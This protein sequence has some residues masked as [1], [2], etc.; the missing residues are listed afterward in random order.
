MRWRYRPFQAAAIAAL[1]AL[2]T[3]CAV[4]APLY[5]RAM[6][7]ALADLAIA[8]ETPAE[9]G[10]QLRAEA[11]E[12]EFAG[13]PTATLPGPE[14]VLRKVPESM[15]AF[16]LDP[17]LSYSAT[18]RP[19]PEGVQDPAGSITWRDGECDHLTFV[20]G[21]CPTDVGDIAISTADARIFGYDVGTTVRV[22]GAESGATRLTV[23]GVYEQVP[24]DFWFGLVLTGYSGV[25]DPVTGVKEH[26]TW[27]SPRATF[28]SPDL[29]ELPGASSSVDLPLDSDNIGVDD[30]LV[31]SDDIAGFEAQVRHDART[32]VEIHVVTGLPDI[33]QDIRVQTDQSRVTVPLLMAQ[34]GLLAV[35]VLWLVLLAVTEQRRP[36]V[37]LAR[38][39]GRGRRGARALLLGELL[40]VAL[41]GV[42]PGVVAALLGSWFART[43]LLPGHA[44]FELRLP[45][46]A[47]VVLAAA[48][49]ALVTVV[50]VSR[51]VREPVE[52]LLRR[53]PPRH[54]RWGL[55]V[56]DALVI[57]GAGTLVVAFATGGLDGPI[58][59]AAPGLLAIVVGLV[60]AHLTSPTASIVGRRLLR[61]GRVRSGVSVLDAARSPATRRI[62]AVVT[63]ASALAVFSAD[64]YVVGDRNR[65]S[66]AAQEAGARLVASVSGNNLD[67]V[68]EAL[69][70]V[71][72]DGQRATPVVRVRPAGDGPSTLAVVPDAFRSI[73]VFPGGAP[74]ASLWDALA[75]PDVEPIEV[76][77]T[78]VSLDVEGSTLESRRIDGESNPVTVGLDLV[79]AGETLHTTL[80]Q[81]STPGDH[82]LTNDVSCTDGCY[83]TGIWVGTLPGATIAGSA[84]LSSPDFDIGP[85]DQ[86]VDVRDQE[87]GSF[88]AQSSRPDRLRI[89]VESPGTTVFTLPQV[90]VPR[91]VPALVPTSADPGPTTFAVVG[92]DGEERSASAAGTLDRVPASAPDTN[93]VNLDL[94]ERGSGVSALAQIEVWFAHDDPSLLRDLTKALDQRGIVLTDVTTLD[95]VRTTYDDTV[96]AWSLQLSGLVG[97]VSLLIALLVLVVSAVSGWRFRTR[98]LAALRMSGVSR[99]SIR[100]MAVAGQLPAVLIGVVAGSI[101]GVYGA[102]LALPI[103]PLFATAPEVST[104]D[105]DTAWA[106]TVGAGVLAL[107][108]LGLGATLIGRT[109]ARRS[110]VRRL[111]E[112]L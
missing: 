25:T 108:V 48:V 111:R 79:R 15:Q 62:V 55:G 11:S 16:Y 26:D 34:L 45:V 112:T 17:I 43:V 96:A 5:D 110:D 31:L 19:L 12:P 58:A 40:P 106:A 41:V 50:A 7:Q 84:V 99:R 54:T 37:A 35:V 4:F 74:P 86:W 65:A 59:L 73:A 76:T 69:D 3:A 6:Q 51:I 89:T 21:G 68:R 38:L 70:Q 97:V 105:L 78:E 104:L 20:D 53:V 67:A 36:E 29:P 91:T 85:A 87:N 94:V 14:Q 44:P 57:A 8:H 13:A 60:I 52:T 95:D 47:S 81:V 71:D 1:A 24:G 2:I 101:C 88:K 75:V 83:V 77:G 90:W 22:A 49:L 102:Q 92:L 27:L 42:V 64:A 63:L 33:A 72:P 46:L 82:H 30:V 103:V 32:Q 28:D 56:A 93:V 100:S 109:L 66:A 10:L 18:V 39:R 9:V 80:G 98:D 23:T 61:R 107:V